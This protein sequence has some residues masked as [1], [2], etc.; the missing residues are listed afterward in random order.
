[1]STPEDPDGLIAA[2]ALLLAIPLRP[3]WYPA[4]RMHLEITLA[5]ARLVAAFDLPDEAEPAPVFRA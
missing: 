4:I 3:E 1:M 2:A 5:H